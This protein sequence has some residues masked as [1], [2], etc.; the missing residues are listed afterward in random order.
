MFDN[1]KKISELRA[2]LKEANE[3]LTQAREYRDEMEII[4]KRE[5]T[6][7][8]V[9]LADQHNCHQVAMN[10]I[11][12]ELEVS[13]KSVPLR[14]AKE[15]AQEKKD[16]RIAKEKQDREHADRMKKLEAEHAAKIAKCE[17]DLETDKISYRKYLK[18][19]FNTKIESLEKAN[20]KLSEEASV[21]RAE[22]SALSGS[23]ISLNIINDSLTDSVSELSKGM[24]ALS[25]KIGDGLVKALPTVTADFNTPEL[26]E[27]HVHVEV[28]GAKSQGNNNQDKK[29]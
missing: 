3:N 17:R 19:E 4:L 9:E 20:L 1:L 27:N 21:L 29:N 11:Q 25:A 5:R 8:K 7:H 6:D 22:N 24:V 13:E 2:S 28:P 14:V 12:N 18:Q 15:V 23:N 16:L 26:P 10:R